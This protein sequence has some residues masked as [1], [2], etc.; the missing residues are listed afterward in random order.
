MPPHLALI[1]SVASLAS[2]L[3]PFRVADTSVRTAA[4][5]QV[6]LDESLVDEASSLED[7]YV[8]SMTWGGGAKKP[9]RCVSRLVEVF[10]A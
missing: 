8:R 6:E 5:N 9:F 2:S 7:V 1:G 10:L 4:I 3:F